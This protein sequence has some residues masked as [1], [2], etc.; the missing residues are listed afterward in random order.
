MDNELVIYTSMSQCIVALATAHDGVTDEAMKNIV[1]DA[2]LICLS[3]MSPQETS[4]DLMSFDG[5]KL[6]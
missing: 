2:A 4:A 5:G 1:H 6:Q 3:V